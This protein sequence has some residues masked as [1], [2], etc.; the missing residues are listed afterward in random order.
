LMSPSP[1]WG[2]LGKPI[3]KPATGPVRFNSGWD[4]PGDLGWEGGVV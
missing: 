1:G 4:Y 2:V 3:A